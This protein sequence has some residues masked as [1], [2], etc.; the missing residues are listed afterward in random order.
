MTTQFEPQSPLADQLAQA[1]SVV[2]TLRQRSEHY[3]AFRAW[4]LKCWSGCAHGFDLRV[5]TFDDTA[6]ALLVA[7]EASGW[8]RRGS[9]APRPEQKSNMHNAVEAKKMARWIEDCAR[10]GLPDP[11][12]PEHFHWEPCRESPSYCEFVA[13]VQLERFVF[14]P[15]AERWRQ[16]VLQ[17]EKAEL[18]AIHE[19]SSARLAEERAGLSD[20]RAATAKRRAHT[21]RRAYAGYFREYA[22]VACAAAAACTHVT[23]GPVSSQL[24]WAV[25]RVRSWLP[26]ML[27]DD[28][29]WSEEDAMEMADVA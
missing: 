15:L 23:S 10:S 5:S 3:A 12:R 9:F 29:A 8:I 16:Y 14:E 2:A 26:N 22:V 13:F 7:A 25:K 6:D 17:A 28:P 18:R 1:R 27:P 24:R 4:C 11:R 20:R 21:L 19:S